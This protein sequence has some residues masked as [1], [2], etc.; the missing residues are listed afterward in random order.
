MMAGRFHLYWNVI[1]GSES[2]AAVSEMETVLLP[3]VRDDAP[4]T[5]GTIDK[6]F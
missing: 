2:F 4:L 6:Y 3:I 5:Y 1:M